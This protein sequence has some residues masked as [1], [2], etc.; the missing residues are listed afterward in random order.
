MDRCGIPEGGVIRH[1]DVTGKICPAPSSDVASLARRV[2]NG[3]F[4]NGEARKWALGSRYFVRDWMLRLICT[5]FVQR[6]PPGLIKQQ[7]RSH[8]TG[9]RQYRTGVSRQSFDL[10]F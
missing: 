5:L 2:I 1:C 9:T 6:A 4:G 7:V 3:E 8:A 10:H